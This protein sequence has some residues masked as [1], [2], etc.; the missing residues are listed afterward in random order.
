[1]DAANLVKDC[2][3]LPPTPTNKADDR[4]ILI[5]LLILKRCLTASSNKT[6][7]SF[8]VFFGSKL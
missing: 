6:K 2:F 7:S 3:P 5:I 4:G 8:L 1:M